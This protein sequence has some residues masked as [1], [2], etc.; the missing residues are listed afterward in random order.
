[1]IISSIFTAL[2]N[3]KQ[4]IL[5]NCILVSDIKIYWSKMICN[6]RFVHKYYSPS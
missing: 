5:E 6:I 4:I 3:I 1:M 2:Y